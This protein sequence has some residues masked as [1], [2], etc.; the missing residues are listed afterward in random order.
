MDYN[1]YFESRLE[2][3]KMKGGLQQMEFVEFSSNSLKLTKEG[4]MQFLD[5]FPKGDLDVAK[6]E[7]ESIYN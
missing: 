7:L 1:K 4:L 2:P 6:K 3:V 5:L